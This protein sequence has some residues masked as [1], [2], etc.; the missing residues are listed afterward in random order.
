MPLPSPLQLPAPIFVTA[1]KQKTLAK[2]ITVTGV[3]VHSN[4]QST[5]TIEP[6]SANSG[7]HIASHLHPFEKLN[8]EQLEDIPMCTALRLSCG[9]RVSMVEHLLAA[10]AGMG[11]FNAAIRVLGTELPILDGSASP[12]VERLTQA[13]IVELA[14]P[15][16]GLCL[17]ALELQDGNSSIY[18]T[19]STESGLQITASVEIAHSGFG[20]HRATFL[21]Q[22]PQTFQQQLAPARTFGFLEDWERLK[23]QNRARGAS[24]ENTIVFT[25]SG[26]HPAQQLRLDQEP[27]RHKIIDIIGDLAIVGYPICG[28][29]EAH[30][31]S[32][33]CNQRLVALLDRWVRHH[34]SHP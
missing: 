9:H 2:P 28:I 25:A 12:W 34:Q 22:K 27:L 29:V 1:G 33:R 18:C 26:L 10:L 4:Q 11:V 20:S 21:L 30:Q 6:M 16:K 19:P 14:E 8:A 17:P 15:Q 7:F 31:P 5:V 24:L 13:G 3:G 32:H 23:Q